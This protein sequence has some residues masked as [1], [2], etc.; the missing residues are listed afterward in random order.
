MGVHYVDFTPRLLEAEAQFSTLSLTGDVPGP[1]YEDFETVF[2]R[3]S[4]W[5]YRQKNIQPIHCEIVELIGVYQVESSLTETTSHGRGVFSKGIP[6]YLKVIR[7]WYKRLDSWQPLETSSD[8]TVLKYINVMPARL[9]STPRAF[10]PKFQTLSDAMESLNRR[11]QEDASVI[12]GNI[13]SIQTCVCRF[14]TKHCSV[15]PDRTFW[16]VTNT[17]D[18]HVSYFFRIFYIKSKVQQYNYRLGFRDFTP[19][20]EWKSRRRRDQLGESFTRLVENASQWLSHNNHV[21]MLNCDSVIHHAFFRCARDT[22]GMEARALDNPHFRSTYWGL[23]DYVRI[24]RVFYMQTLTPPNEEVAPSSQKHLLSKVFHVHPAIPSDS[25]RFAGVT[26]QL[27]LN[28]DQLVHK[29]NDWIQQNGIEV[30]GVETVSV[31]SNLTKVSL[32]VDDT[33]FEAANKGPVFTIYGLRL[34]FTEP[35]DSA[36]KQVD[37]NPVPRTVR[38][39]EDSCAIL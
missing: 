10:G 23:L 4:E 8:R 20:C 15:D 37:V 18:M 1:Q 36:S 26:A 35:L 17:E 2:R 14:S 6:S 29:I 34:Y 38:L 27:P 7:V 21:T 19:Q 39:D 24:L 30:C 11:L 28:H 16:L 33:V 31:Q 22:P 9:E 12:K 32:S 3:C 13:L 5:L 25:I